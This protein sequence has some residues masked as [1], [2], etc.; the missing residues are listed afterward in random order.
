MNIRRF[1]RVRRLPS[2]RYQARYHGPDGMDRPAP[3]TF[4]TK[5]EAEAWLVRTEADILNDDW[6]NP[7]DG[8]VP[9]GE[10]A[11]DWIDHRPELRPKTVELYRYLLRRHLN[12]TFETRPIAG[13]KEPQIRRWRK[14]LLD[15]G[16]SEVTAAKAYRLLKAIFATAAD[17]G[18]I[19]RNPC[20][21]KGAGQ[22]HSPERPVLTIAQVYAVANAVDQRYQALVLLAMFSSLRWGELAALRRCD[23][24]L[25]ARTV[26]VTRQLT[27]IRGGGQHFGP[28]KSKAGLRTVPI[29]ELIVSVIRWHLNCFAQDGD[30][31]T[32][33]HFHDLRHTGNTLAAN[34]GASLRELMDRMGRD[35]ERAA[36]IYLHGS[37]A[38]QQAIADSL[39]KLA[40]DE[41]KRTGT[42]GTTPTA[43]R[44]GTQRARRRPKAS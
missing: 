15:N 8:K 11:A 44:S 34:A 40:R 16:V 1:G 23:I 21:I 36:L 9:F 5:G 19:K 29:P 25:D 3:E 32:G 39:D 14:Q 28:P 13:I 37:D 27:E 10:F 22:E 35:S 30:G 20:R 43:K 18:V 4:A 2:G 26:R 12:P 7:D 42:S 17:D 31:L 33:V 24:D 6:F 38:R 41:L